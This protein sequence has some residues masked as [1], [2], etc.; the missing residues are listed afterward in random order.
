MKEHTVAQICGTKAS[1]RYSVVQVKG[2]RR[3]V[4]HIME[5]VASALG[6]FNE[7]LVV[8]LLCGGGVHSV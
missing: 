8:S 2:G 7:A 6:V 1:F 3:R 4:P 5:Q